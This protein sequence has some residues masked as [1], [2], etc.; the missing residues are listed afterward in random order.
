MEKF[1][2]A[3][4]STIAAGINSTDLSVT[5]GAGDGAEFPTMGADDT[6]RL[7]IENELILVRDRA[8]DVLSW[9]SVADRGIEG[10]TAAAHSLGV[11][12]ELVP[13]DES[14]RSTLPVATIWSTKG[15]LIVGTGVE[16]AAILAPGADDLFLA[17]DSGEATGLIWRALPIPDHGD[18]GAV[19]ADQHHTEGHTLQSHTGSWE[20]GDPEMATMFQ[21]AVLAAQAS[22]NSTAFSNLTDM[23]FDVEIDSVYD[24]ELIVHMIAPTTDDLKIQFTVPAGTTIKGVDIGMHD[25]AP[26]SS[27]VSANYKNQSVAAATMILSGIGAQEVVH[28]IRLVVDSAGT[29]GTCQL[30]G[31]L[32]A[33][34]GPGTFEVG[35]RMKARKLA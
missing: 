20:P 5:V 1:A 35:T 24:V 28:V 7:L 30:Q 14:I 32:N 25:S 19:T 3:A 16:T 27:Q 22:R 13:T 26:T 11:E 15:E 12:A 6:F 23:N 31:A 17:L 9:D 34:T 33:N 4:I 18:L 8:G 2:N 21:E 29:A 10:T